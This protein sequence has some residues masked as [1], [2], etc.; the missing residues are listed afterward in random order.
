MDPQEMMKN[1]EN[2]NDEQKE[3]FLGSFFQ[4][5]SQ[6]YINRNPAVY[7][8]DNK[9]MEMA[10][11]KGLFLLPTHFYAPV[12]TKIEI[13]KYNAKN[14]AEGIDWNDAVQIDFMERSRESQR[15]LMDTPVQRRNNVEYYWDNEAFSHT[16][17]AFYY[18]LIRLLKPKQVLEIGAGNSTK[19]AVKALQA[20]G[21]RN[22]GDTLTVIEP[23]P[24]KDLATM[25]DQF[26]LQ[27]RKQTLQDTDLETFQKL[28]A[29]DI[30][31]FDGT[32]VSKYGSDVNHFFFQ[33][34]PALNSGVYVHVHDIFLPE[35]MPKDW[36]NDLNLFWNE[37]YVLH[38]FLM[39]NDQFE[40]VFSSKYAF[41]KHRTLLDDV[42]RAPLAYRGNGGGSLWMRK[43]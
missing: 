12:P 42:F 39:Y 6:N 18:S 32:H 31:F 13:Q 33:I 3:E 28:Q 35:E 1:I 30:L 5:L 17:A 36:V 4:W 38:A 23:Y 9:L 37:Q 10:Q 34:L 41:M 26:D 8:P 21:K 20:L 15:D 14:G 2:M 11:N 19:M 22:L 43:K 16:D 29:G 25:S 7:H 40:I 27:I 24:S